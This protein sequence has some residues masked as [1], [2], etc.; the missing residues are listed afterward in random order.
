MARTRL[1]RPAALD[2]TALALA[3]DAA[4]R[5]SLSADRARRIRCSGAAG[6]GAH[7]GA[8][9]DRLAAVKLL[10]ELDDLRRCA[11]ASELMSYV[12]LVPSEHSSG[13]ERRRAG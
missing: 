11:R 9:V 2:A 8:R 6:A 3:R 13:E 5:V 10:A 1:R 4:F 12:G 7:G